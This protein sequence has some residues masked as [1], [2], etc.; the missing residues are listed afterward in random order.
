L[1][2]DLFCVGSYNII[3][4]RKGD[5]QGKWQVVGQEKSIEGFGEET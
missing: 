2:G 3:E 5:G 4:V 1:W